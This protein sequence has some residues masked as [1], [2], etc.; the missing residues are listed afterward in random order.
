MVLLRRWPLPVLAA[1]VAVCGLVMAS[2]AEPLPLAVLVGV[3]CYLVASR[4]PRRVSIAAVAVAAA[5]LGAALGYAALARTGGRWRSRRLRV[6]AVGGGVVRGGCGRGA[7]PIPGG[8]GGARGARAG[9]RGRACPPGGPGGARAHRPGAARCRRPCSGGDHG[10]GRRGQTADGGAAGGPRR[11]HR[12]AGVDCRG[13]AAT[14]RAGCSRCRAGGYQHRLPHPSARRPYRGGSPPVVLCSFPMRWSCDGN[15][16]RN[17]SATSRYAINER[18]PQ[19]SG[20]L[21]NAAASRT[22]N[23]RSGLLLPESVGVS[24]VRSFSGALWQT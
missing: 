18:A 10:S 3:A 24:G 22:A 4:V 13:R 15:P 12:S 21:R 14:Q 8:F 1:T 11:A 20:S 9:G 16:K 17:P 7:P 2:G 5:A 6:L 19:R 23:V